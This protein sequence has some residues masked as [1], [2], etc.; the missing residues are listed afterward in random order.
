MS[1]KGLH[2]EGS[3]IAPFWNGLAVILIDFR[4]NTL[5]RKSI[6][7]THLSVR[8]STKTLE[9]PELGHFEECMKQLS[10][11][12]ESISI[13]MKGCGDSYGKELKI[14]RVHLPRLTSIQFLH[15]DHVHSK[16]AF[17]T[18]GWACRNRIKSLYISRCSL[19]FRLLSKFVAYTS[20]LEDLILED[21]SAWDAAEGVV[22]LEL[23]GSHALKRVQV[24]QY[25]GKG[26]S[27]A[28]VAVVGS[29]NRTTKTTW[30]VV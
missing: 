9:L 24:P 5:C 13:D 30:K 6:K 21:C 19:V 1:I 17:A 18:T 7:L 27:E 10:T 12:L 20:D 26:A 28:S 8:L 3:V 14:I 29:K 25:C 11:T 4:H 16:D 15:L 22:F 2:C 23:P